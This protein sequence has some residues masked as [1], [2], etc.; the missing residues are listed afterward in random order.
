MLELAASIHPLGWLALIAVL[1]ALVSLPQALREMWRR[2]WKDD[3][4]GRSAKTDT[5]GGPPIAP[6]RDRT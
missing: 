6:D 4:R 3:A 2:P 5:H 1:V